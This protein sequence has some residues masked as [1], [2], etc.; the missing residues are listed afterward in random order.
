MSRLF[1]LSLVSLISIFLLT[2]TFHALVGNTFLDEGEYLYTGYT[3]IEDNTQLYIDTFARVPP[4][5]YLSYGSVLQSFGPDI[6]N[7]RIFSIVLALG[8]F[9][10]AF[11]IVR[12]LTGSKWAG[13][14]SVALLASTQFVTQAFS[15]ALPLALSNF[16]ILGSIF[17]L[18]KSKRPWNYY[19]STL[20][21]VFACL[22]RQNLG[23]LFIILMIYLFFIE[24]T[25]LKEKI[26]I[27]LISI[28]V[29]L[30]FFWKGIV[31]DAP[32][33]IANVFGTAFQSL[34]P[35]QLYFEGSSFISR[36]YYIFSDLN[37]LTILFGLTLFVLLFL[38]L[39]G[40][41]AREVV[42]HKYILLIGGMFV[43]NYFFH[44]FGWKGNNSWYSIYSVGL[45]AVLLGF[46]FYKLYYYLQ[47][48]KSRKVLVL[49]LVSLIMI[50][51]TLM[52]RTTLINPIHSDTHLNKISFAAESVS[53]LTNKDD[54][55][56]IFGQGLIHILLEADRR[57][58]APLTNEHYLYT[59]ELDINQVERYGFYNEAMLRTWL[60]ESDVV[61]LPR[62]KNRVA[63]KYV[64]T[65]PIVLEILET[66]YGEPVIVESAIPGDLINSNDESLEIYFKI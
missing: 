35:F 63:S 32:V 7:G 45:L 37:K 36:F 53:E 50:N 65:L 54:Q 47:D 48:P 12:K 24:K 15:R 16:F 11:G 27:S 49:V 64:D 40:N 29:P 41:F 42:S 31:A 17:F 21:I 26:G 62:D 23:L 8:V 60:D 38:G 44:T 30:A 55:I 19:F 66:Q 59:S 13:L 3:T 4:L 61:M 57:T 22:T 46:V 20:F 58:V 34:T 33:V 43:V 25:K 1:K 39:T 5:M 10:F 6:I 51:F 14:L 52:D 9:F 28:V 2:A 18:V 56:L